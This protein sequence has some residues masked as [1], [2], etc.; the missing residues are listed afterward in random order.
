MPGLSQNKPVL[1]K[2]EPFFIFETKR[3][4]LDANLADFAVNRLILSQIRL[5]L[6]MLFA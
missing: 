2:R 6:I 4:T 1:P 5:T 3:P